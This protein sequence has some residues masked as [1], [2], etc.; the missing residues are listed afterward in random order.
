MMAIKLATMTTISATVAKNRLLELIRSAEERGEEFEI[1]RNGVPS[2]VLVSAGEWESLTETL[3]ILADPR[4]R[5]A[6]SEA[7]RELAAGRTHSHREVWN[8][9]G[10]PNP[11]PP[12]RLARRGGAPARRGPSRPARHRKAR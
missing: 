4:T 6:L 9:N 12:A 8:E 11:L 2:A 3:E 1:T 10:L 5:R 7:R